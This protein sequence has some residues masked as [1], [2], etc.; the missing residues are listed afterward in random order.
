MPK[1][2]AVFRVLE[3]DKDKVPFRS[4]FYDVPPAFNSLGKHFM[5]FAHEVG[6][7]T[8]TQLKELMNRVGKKYK[9]CISEDWNADQVK[10]GI[11]FLI[12]GSI[13]DHIGK[14][15]GADTKLDLKSMRRRYVKAK[16]DLQFDNT[17]IAPLA[18]CINVVRNIR[19]SHVVLTSEGVDSPSD[20]P[21]VKMGAKTDSGSAARKNYDLLNNEGKRALK[22][23][24]AL[25]ACKKENLHMDI[26]DIA[27]L[28]GLPE[29]SLNRKPYKD[30]I[31]QGRTR[32]R[33]ERQR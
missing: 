23:A 18:H 20:K 6:D 26:K 22:Q 4:K 17:I 11:I 32:A 15:L 24:A 31:K 27:I 1:Y 14:E 2:H 3:R 7:L 33:Q 12:E 19:N 21:P 28:W 9:I 13:Y 30:I 16:K 10:H 29:K 25:D 8:E 5:S